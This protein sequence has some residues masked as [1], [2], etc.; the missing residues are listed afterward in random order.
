MS[1][2][3]VNL[4]GRIEFKYGEK[5]LEH[6]LSNKGIALISLLMMDMG[7]EVSREKLITYLWADSDE[8]AARYNLRYNLWS[9]KKLIPSDEAGQELIVSRRDHCL[10]NP[11]YDFRSDMLEL[12]KFENKSAE[13]TLEELNACKEL[14]RGDFLEGIY[15]KNCDDFNEKII[16]ERIV[17][18]NKYVDLL[19]E[20][21]DK[22]EIYQNYGECIRVLNELISIE[23]Y[24]EK[25]VEKLIRAYA[26]WGKR[27]EV[28]NYFKKFEASLR[29][30]LNIAPGKELKLVYQKLMKELQMS[31]GETSGESRIRKQSIEI[32]VQ[33][34][35]NIDYFCL[36]D[37]IRKIILK[38]DRKYIFGLSKCYLED[39][40]FIQLEVG[41]G[42]EK[43]Y[44]DKCTLHSSLP[45]VR[46]VDAFVKFMRY[47]SE[48]YT[49][50]I[51]II[52]PGEMDRISLNIL[53]YIK[54]LQIKDVSFGEEAEGGT[55]AARP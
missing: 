42:Y 33:C 5:P 2:L 28:I 10:L 12:M 13:R 40:N 26:K 23:P 19:R 27:S 11:D 15:L 16:F 6:K 25:A 4:L 1:K 14:F 30:N 38:G 54:N 35:E 17:Y 21:A 53:N 3:S 36:S 18:Q 50:K 43:L 24:N 48:I 37:I 9:I 32:E 39:L 47:V 51:I 49:L 22:Y 44:T 45:G 41:L 46:I 7:K 20:I 55:G 31:A 29:S 52:N 34:V 8:E